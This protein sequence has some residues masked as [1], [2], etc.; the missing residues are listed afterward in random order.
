M[1]TSDK[2][3]NKLRKEF[4]YIEELNRKDIFLFSNKSH[5]RF[6]GCFN[7]SS[8]GLKTI[9]SYYTMT[10]CLKAKNLILKEDW[11]NGKFNGWVVSPFCLL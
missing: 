6:G 8:N 9:H 4:P 1:K 7:W 3:L 5:L 11:R 10:D 2:L